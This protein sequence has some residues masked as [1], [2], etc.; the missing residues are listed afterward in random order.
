MQIMCTQSLWPLERGVC[1]PGP[2]SVELFPVP[3]FVAQKFLAP[4]PPVKAGEILHKSFAEFQI[5]SFC[6]LSNLWLLFFK[7]MKSIIFTFLC[8][9]FR[10]GIGLALALRLATLLARPVNLLL[11]FA[12]KFTSVPFL[13]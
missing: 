7:Y 13:L 11:N 12:Y 5:K 6:S 1:S 10:R 2:T 4:R 3:S 9:Y 8:G